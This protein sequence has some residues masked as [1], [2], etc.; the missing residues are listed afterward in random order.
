M[1]VPKMDGAREPILEQKVL[2]H[3]DPAINAF[4]DLRDGENCM[5][6]RLRLQNFIVAACRRFD[7]KIVWLVA[8]GVDG[9]RLEDW[10]SWCVEFFIDIQTETL[11]RFSNLIIH[12]ESHDQR[13]SNR[14]PCEFGNRYIGKL[15]RCYDDAYKSY[16]DMM[17]IQPR[18]PRH[19]KKRDDH[20][21]KPYLFERIECSCP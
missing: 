19:Q 21:W 10:V 17:A 1:G 2:R 5:R 18:T 9:K 6:L 14:I 4:F 8:E 15:G 3:L 16:M 11:S 12:A 20:S 7:E 13:V